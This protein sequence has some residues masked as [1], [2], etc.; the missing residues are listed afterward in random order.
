VASFLSRWSPHRSGWWA[1]VLLVVVGLLLGSLFSRSSPLLV[2]QTSKNPPT[3]AGIATGVGTAVLALVT[4]CASLI[5][6]VEYR[7]RRRDATSRAITRCDV[8]VTADC[9]VYQAFHL[10]RARVE[11]C[12]R[13]TTRMT[14]SDDVP[15]FVSVR[16]V[17]DGLLPREGGSLTD[18]V[19][20][21]GDPLAHC[22]VLEQEFLES[23][24]TLVHSCLLSIFPAQ[25]VCAYRV[26][27][28]IRVLEPSDDQV[29]RWRAIDY[30]PVLMGLVGPTDATM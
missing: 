25:D 11:V 3:W 22:V 15:P 18:H 17:T 30:V 16:A 2:L 19:F 7:T 29:Y 13:S 27:F 20:N 10:I 9:F 24:E 23:E 21:D 5:A 8:R 26:Q 12:N 4:L 6:Y 1:L 28:E 14:I